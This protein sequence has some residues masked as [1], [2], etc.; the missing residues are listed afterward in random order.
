MLRDWGFEA[1]SNPFS[2]TADPA[3]ADYDIYFDSGPDRI[4]LEAKNDLRSATTPFF[5]LERKAIEHSLAP[6][7]VY[8]IRNPDLIWCFHRWELDDLLNSPSYRHI[9][10]GQYQEENVLVPKEVLGSVGRPFEQ[11]IRLLTKQA[12]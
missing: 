6:L 8:H 4:Y 10:A 2:G 9:A 5:C 12:A 1:G 3:R 11:A 7:F